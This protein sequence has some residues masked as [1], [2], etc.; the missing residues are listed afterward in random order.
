MTGSTDF[1]KPIR[2]RFVSFFARLAAVAALGVSVS[3]TAGFA[4]DAMT[5]IS[6]DGKVRFELLL[7]ERALGY[8]V[9]FNDRLV[10]E[11]SM[12]RVRLDD[13]ELSEG[14]ELGSAERYEVNEKYPWRGVHS[15][16]VNRC[17]GARI[18][19]KQTASDTSFTVE[20]RAFN[21]GIAFRHL[22]P[23]GVR[24][25]VPDETTTFAIAAGSTAWFHGLGGHYEAVHEKKGI[26]DI[27]PGE[28]AA[29]PLTF[30]L[31]GGAGYGAIT[32]AALANYSGMALQAD[33]Q[34][35]FKIVLG[36]K[37][38]ISYP[39]RLRY[40]NDV[41]RVSRPASI[42][43]TIASPWR[44]VMLGTNLNAL[45]NSDLV[46]NLCPSPDTNLFPKGVDTG[47]IKPGR[48][49]WKYLDGGANTFESMKEFS[50]LAGQLGF[51]YHVIEGF[52]SRWSDDQ[53]RELVDDSRQQGVGLW[54]W[55]HSREL[56]TPAARTQF[57]ARLHGLGVVGAK[58]D[59]FDHEHKE[60]VDLY[61][62]LLAEAARHQVMVN[63]H[64]AN[65]PT[66]EARTWPNELIREGVR[67][68]ESSRLQERARH[69]VTLPF[70][71]FLAGHGDYTPVHFGARRGDTTWA[72]QIATA[73]VFNEPLLT[74]GAHPTNLL[75]SSAVEMIKSIPAV[76]DETIVLPMSEIGE[77]A[78]F[79]RRR[80]SLWFL[81]ILNG[82]AART[83]EV[84]CTFLGPGEYEMS[85]VRDQPGESAAVNVEARG[86]FSSQS[87]S[88]KIGLSAGGGFIARFSKAPR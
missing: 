36:H 50:R 12:M 87:D 11:P 37:H 41:E 40:S 30:K 66:G 52:W 3:W 46:H 35:G 74:Y 75:N 51:E 24:P 53:I 82:P 16:A 14:V 15:E 62:A 2:R 4:A 71:R 72:H 83:L 58:I 33:G 48:A 28:W 29:L 22:I 17:N 43:G 84:P 78:A 57:F 70:T 88:L 25:R 39:F 85:L 49:V 1:P 69:N 27:T 77:L 44:V 42:A 61:H 26:A 68:M 21:D 45:V 19:V 6:P 65:K 38:P 31:P 55:R 56:R 9:S 86:R 10:I 73:A 8:R 80:G 5:A 76:W 23:G 18:P 79:A 63:F 59:F 67:G 7:R 13:A 64:G 54:L 34:R 47:W 32:E 20:V 81:A 60:V